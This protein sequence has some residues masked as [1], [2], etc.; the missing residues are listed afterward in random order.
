MSRGSN[1]WLGA[2]A[3]GFALSIVAVQPARGDAVV[4]QDFED[5]TWHEELV[6]VRT[7]DLTNTRLVR[8]FLGNGLAVSIPEGGYR[9]LGTRARTPAPSPDEAWFRYYLRLSD[10]WPAS[11]GKL[12]GLSGIYHHTGLGC[13]PSTAEAPGWSGRM[14]FEAAGTHGAA[15]DEVPIGYYLYH[16]GQA[17]NCG[18]ELMWDEALRQERWYCLEGHVRL[19][20][21]S[22]RDGAVDAWVDGR[23]AF[24]LGGLRFRRVGE[25]G[26]GIRE[27]FDNVYFGGRYPTPNPLRLVLDQ[28]VVSDSGRVGCLDPFGDDNT[29]IHEEMINE[30]H[31]RGV[32][33]GCAEG[34]ACPLDPITRVEFAALLHRVLDLPAGPDAFA[35]DEEHWGEA[36]LNS[37]AAA[38]VVRGCNPPANNLACPHLEVTRAE[39]AAMVKRALALPPGPD[40]FRD[41]DGHWAE[42]DINALAAS[43]ITRGCDEAGYCPDRSITRQEAA[44]FMVRIDDRLGAAQP[45]PPSIASTWQPAGPPPVVPA[46]ER[47]VPPSYH[48]TGSWDG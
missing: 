7:T 20:T 45:L 11:S 12:P 27:M 37:L 26:V 8:G 38:G 23:P 46:D 32:F 35:D 33:F 9:G 17:G 10:F 4:I 41:D 6:D 21:P 44:S 15:A 3:L 43:G 22:L 5:E 28:V 30:L 24:S 25:R 16:L 34:W 40:S 14:M 1:R 2:L 31:A 29:S 48:Q 39:V 18:D 19:N 42:G 47:E 36:A 13:Y